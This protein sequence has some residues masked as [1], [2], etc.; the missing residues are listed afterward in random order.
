[1]KKMF[2]LIVAL[3]MCLS[4]AGCGNKL[5]KQADAVAAKLEGTWTF[6]WNAPIGKMKVVYEFSN[7][8]GNAGTIKETMYIGG[9][10]VKTY[11]GVFGVNIQEDGVIDCTNMGEIGNGGSI[12]QLDSPVNYTL[13]YTYEDG[14]LTLVYN[15]ISVTK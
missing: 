10:K 8:D 13:S 2:A 11:T 14:K 7:V 3:A 4:F 1:M 12:K 9:E 6:S 5:H 15:D